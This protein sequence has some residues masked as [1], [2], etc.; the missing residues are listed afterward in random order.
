MASKSAQLAHLQRVPLFE[1]CSKR[2]LQAIQKAG[3]ELSMTAGTL[4]I[5]QGQMGHEAFVLLE[6][7]VTVRRN[8]RKI[9]TLGAGSIIGE[10]SLLD[11]GPRAASVICDTDCSL[12]VIDQHHFHSVIEHQ[13]RLAMKLLGTLAAR[14]REV[15]R[16]AYG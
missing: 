3:D 11:H 7:S 15:D 14:I 6:G 12:F 13:P 1:S 2:E 9:T 5:D 10:L 8:G 16:A 4:L